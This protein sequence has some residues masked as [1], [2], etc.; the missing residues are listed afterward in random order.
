M[1]IYLSGGGT[2]EDMHNVNDH[3]AENIL[4]KKL[5]VIPQAAAPGLV[6]YQFCRDFIEYTTEFEPLLIKIFETLENN[7]FADISILGGI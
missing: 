7:T 6:S 5:L 1:K 3:F 4:N 2:V